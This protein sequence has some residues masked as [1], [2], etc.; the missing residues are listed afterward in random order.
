MTKR[1]LL[2][3]TAALA[4]LIS[5]PAIAQTVVFDVLDTTT[6]GS[7]IDTGSSFDNNGIWLTMASGSLSIISDGSFPGYA[8]GQYQLNTNIF[9]AD[10]TANIYTQGFFANGNDVAV[11]GT[12]GQP[13]NPAMFSFGQTVDA[14][15]TYI[16]ASSF[17]TIAGGPG[18]TWGNWNSF[19][20]GAIGVKFANGANIHYG[21]IDV[22]VN[23]NKTITLHGW[24][25]EATPDTGIATFAIPEPSA[26][27][28]LLGFGMIAGLLLRRRR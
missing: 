23:T 7:T 9:F 18:D 15:A 26:F 27:S 20:R 22:T 19:G 6:V 17:T 24:A 2:L 16:G 25:Y 14:S 8:D 12:G 1:S 10:P 21:F 28:L 3:S 5:A 11:A 4:G 13:S